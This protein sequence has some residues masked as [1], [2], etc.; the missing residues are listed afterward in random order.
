MSLQE[1][2]VDLLVDI[3]KELENERPLRFI[4]LSKKYPNYSNQYILGF[5]SPHIK[6]T[7]EKYGIH[8]CKDFSTYFPENIDH[9]LYRHVIRGIFDGD[10]CIS[11]TEAR[12]NITGNIQLI[13]FIKQHIE[14][15]LNIHVTMYTPHKKDKQNTSTR[16]MQIAGARQLSIFLD[17]IYKDSNLHIKR[18]YDLY[19]QKYCKD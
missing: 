7:L 11:K 15:E 16:T 3:N 2:D 6:D 9:D 18:K 19:C 12:C 8:P 4:E 10:G 14:D 17:Y 1:S 5:N 13:S